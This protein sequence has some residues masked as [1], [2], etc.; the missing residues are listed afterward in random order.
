MKKMDEIC[1]QGTETAEM[2]DVAMFKEAKPELCCL[3]SLVA[4]M[5]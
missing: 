3:K 1:L 5:E 4:Q 2:I